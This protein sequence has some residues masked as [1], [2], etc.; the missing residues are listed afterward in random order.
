M[1]EHLTDEEQLE[2]LKTWWK[3]NGR[4]IVMAVLI[5]VIAYF[6]WQWWQQKEQQQ[7]E[8]A[9]VLYTELLE[10]LPRTNNEPLTEDK[11]TTANYLIQQLQDDFPKTQYAAN[12]VLFSAKLAMDKNDL[13]GAEESLLWVSQNA[14]ESLKVLANLRLARVYLAQ[15]KYDQGLALVNGSQP[16]SFVSLYAEVRGDILVAK[17]DIAAARKAYQQAIDSLGE[18][19]QGFRRQ[20]LP[21]KLANLPVGE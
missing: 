18:Q 21:I 7:A 13:A 2:Q 14:Q 15:E 6:G 4:S 8:Q 10:V 12:A 5:G 1:A 3:E 11:Q 16:D 20:L 19:T 17:Q 9:S